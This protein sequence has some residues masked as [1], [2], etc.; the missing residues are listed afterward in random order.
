MSR[1]S[2]L[3]S[4]KTKVRDRNGNTETPEQTECYSCK[5]DIDHG[6]GTKSWSVTFVKNGFVLNA[7]ECRQFYL[8][9]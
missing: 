4:G 8:L 2:Y 1:T 7:L 6:S 5:C 3:R 9:N